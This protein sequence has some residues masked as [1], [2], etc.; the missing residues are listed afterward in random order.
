VTPEYAICGKQTRQPPEPERGVEARLKMKLGKTISGKL[1]G[2][3]AAILCVVMIC[4]MADIWAVWHA[5]NTGQTYRDAIAMVQQRS[6]MD[7][8]INENRMRCSKVWETLSN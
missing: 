7:R 8:A 6:E 5:R 3:F 1:Y 4:F 2:G